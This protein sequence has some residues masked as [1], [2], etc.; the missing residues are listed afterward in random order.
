MEKIYNAG[1]QLR[2]YLHVPK[3]HYKIDE[4]QSYGFTVSLTTVTYYKSVHNTAN[5]SF[6]SRFFSY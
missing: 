2:K 5:L 4:C 6:L 3:L 1:M